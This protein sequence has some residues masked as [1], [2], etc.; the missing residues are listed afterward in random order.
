MLIGA[1]FGNFISKKNHTGVFMNRPQDF[2]D[3]RHKDLN[4]SEMLIGIASISIFKSLD[5]LVSAGIIPG[6]SVGI[7]SNCNLLS[8]PD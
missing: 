1:A 3:D 5:Y 8:I 2:R 7:K 6:L 4:T